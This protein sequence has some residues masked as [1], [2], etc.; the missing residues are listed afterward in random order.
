[1]QPVRPQVVTVHTSFLGPGAAEASA[2][3]RYGPR[4]RAVAMRFERR[5]GRWVCRALE[6]A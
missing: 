5:Q 2:R 1:V 3:I 6:F 4:S